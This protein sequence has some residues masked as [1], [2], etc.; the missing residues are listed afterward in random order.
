MSKRKRAS[1]LKLLGFDLLPLNIFKLFLLKYTTRNS[2]INLVKASPILGNHVKTYDLSIDITLLIKEDDKDFEIYIEKI[3]ES[4]E[5]KHLF[6]D[7]SGPN[8]IYPRFGYGC[9]TRY[10]ISCFNFSLSDIKDYISSLFTIYYN[11][12]NTFSHVVNFSKVKNLIK[13]H[14]SLL[15]YNQYGYKLP[16]CTLK[17]EIVSNFRYNFIQIGYLTNE[18]EYLPLFY[19]ETFKTYHFGLNK[20]STIIMIEDFDKKKNFKIAGKNGF[21]RVMI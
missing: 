18:A 15:T 17:S 3:I 9:K 19:N 4:E 21:F 16:D 12:H 20:S 8:Y 10:L 6:L 1:D 14:E 2:L 13:C 11:Q 5:I 7:K